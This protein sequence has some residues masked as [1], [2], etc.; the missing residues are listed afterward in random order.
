MFPES[1][2]VLGITKPKTTTNIE[3]VGPRRADKN[4]VEVIR[5][6]AFGHFEREIHVETMKL[7]PR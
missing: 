7:L 3:T 6:R 1:A 4:S 5:S 2:S